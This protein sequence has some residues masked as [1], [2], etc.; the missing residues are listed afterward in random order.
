MPWFPTLRKYHQILGYKWGPTDV[1]TRVATIL[2]K[3]IKSC[4]EKLF[5]AGLKNQETSSTLLFM[6]IDR[7]TIGIHDVVVLFKSPT[8]EL[9]VIKPYKTSIRPHPVQLYT[10]DFAAPQ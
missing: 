2:S 4:G 5:R 3:M 8:E 6:S 1:Q 9:E 10:L 7:P